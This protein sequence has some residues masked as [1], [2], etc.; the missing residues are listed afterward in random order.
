MTI[1]SQSGGRHSSPAALRALYERFTGEISADNLISR[2]LSAWSD[3]RNR[4]RSQWDHR[5][6]DSPDLI[7]RLFVPSPASAGPNHWVHPVADAAPELDSWKTLWRNAA[8]AERNELATALVHVIALIES[9]PA[10]V[11]EGFALL[12]RSAGGHSLP[13]AALTPALSSL[14]P[15]RFVVLCDAWVQ[16]LR[17]YEGNDL[18]KDVGAYP[19]VNAVALR[20]L[21]AAEADLRPDVFRDCPPADRLG[22][23]FS[24]ISHTNTGAAPGPKFDVTQKKYK[25]W[26]PMW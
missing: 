22:V 1:I 9:E 25:D 6:S 11:A 23:F 8:S 19:D 18:P 13:L 12:A 24:W 14:D 7:F 20:W 4:W 26:P 21:A 17:Q 16:T 3:A 5:A 15:V 10:S 2:Q